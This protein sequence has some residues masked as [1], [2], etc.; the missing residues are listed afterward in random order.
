MSSWVSKWLINTGRTIPKLKVTFKPR[1]TF[2]DGIRKSQRNKMIHFSHR[3]A[4]GVG[5]LVT[6]GTGM[7]NVP[8]Q[9]SPE[10]ASSC[11]PGSGE[12]GEMTRER[13]KSGKLLSQRREK[14][15][16]TMH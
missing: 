3:T 8:P 6:Y 2:R 15:I 7:E 10:R 16:K 11:F 9:E 1:C 5:H 4:A 14:Y 13:P 12:A